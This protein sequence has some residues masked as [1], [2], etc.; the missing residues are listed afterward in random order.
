V[1]RGRRVYILYPPSWF[2]VKALSL[3]LHH[4]GTIACLVLVK[5]KK[6]IGRIFLAW[7]PKIR[8]I[9]FFF[10]FLYR[11]RNPVQLQ[12]P[13]LHFASIP[14]HYTLYRYISSCFDSFFGGIHKKRRCFGIVG[15][16][17]KSYNIFSVSILSREKKTIVKYVHPIA[18]THP[19]SLINKGETSHS[20]Q[21]ELV[22]LSVHPLFPLFLFLRLLSPRLLRS[23]SG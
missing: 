12:K 19:S 14:Q 22:V 17:T 13:K 1:P 4:A 16:K 11:L 9:Q 2:V 8:L 15:R 20:L 10:S 3:C 5:P 7:S 18:S 6:R 21:P 23:V